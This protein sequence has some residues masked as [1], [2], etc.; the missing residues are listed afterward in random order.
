MHHIR[1][2]TKNLQIHTRMCINRI[3][4]YLKIVCVLKDGDNICILM[5]SVRPLAGNTR[6]DLLRSQVPQ[7]GR[8]TNIELKDNDCAT[9]RQEFVTK[10][11]GCLSEM[12]T[13]EFCNVAYKTRDFINT[14]VCYLMDAA[15]LQQKRDANRYMCDYTISLFSSV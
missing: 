1:F 3:Q 14:D 10:L 13:S 7:R 8:F 11:S 9:C 6:R 12:R 4:K 15:R 2:M 5:R